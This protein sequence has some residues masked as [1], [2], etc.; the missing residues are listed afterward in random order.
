[1]A[2]LL[3]PGWCAAVVAFGLVGR[4]NG[5]ATQSATN[6]VP[7]SESGLAT[8]RDAFVICAWHVLA[9]L[10]VATLHGLRT[11]FCEPLEGYLLYI[12][13]PSVGMVLASALAALTAL[14]VALVPGKLG[15]IRPFVAALLALLFPLGSAFVG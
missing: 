10:V 15:R 2:G 3:G 14:V 1:M 4:L 6:D 5:N 13:G 11:G 8:M 7:L 12:M 9:L